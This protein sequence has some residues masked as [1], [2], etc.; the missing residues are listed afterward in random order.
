MLNSK[1]LLAVTG[2]SRATLNNYIAL[3]LLP[4][5]VVRS[6]GAHEGRATRLGY[7]EN[8]MIE[9]IKQ[10][11]QMKQQGLSM[12]AIVLEL[13]I[14]SSP[15]NKPTQTQPRTSFN[16]PSP[17]PSSYA[18]LTSAGSEQALLKQKLERLEFPLFTGLSVLHAELDD[19]QAICVELPVEE[20]FQ[21]I[22]DIWRQSE[23][24]F[25]TYYGVHGNHPSDGL[26]YYFLPEANS[27]HKLSSVHCAFE[28][29]Q[30][31]ADLSRHWRAS[32]GWS[33]QLHLNIG[34]SEG[35]DWVGCYDNNTNRSQIAS[36]GDTT[37]QASL[38]SQ[39][40]SAGSIWISKNMLAQLHPDKRSQLRY[41]ISSDDTA[42]NTFTI[43]GR[44][45][46]TQMHGI[47]AI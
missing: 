29:R 11:Q 42:S 24:V 44:L 2:I 43:V 23:T 18:G 36:L 15:T 34:L 26:Q 4:S 21:L 30:I 17:L 13:G 10:V 38:L 33:R 47:V 39:H 19:R 16:D 46:A 37:D 20:Y 14:K 45:P 1:Q 5:P 9:R 41:G 32:K 12:A 6:P 27:D 31:M 25:Q 28:L 40:A 3:G 8:E 22:S 35:R 7:F